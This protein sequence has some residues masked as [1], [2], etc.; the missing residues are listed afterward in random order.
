MIKSQDVVERHRVG[1]CFHKANCP[2]HKTHSASRCPLILPAPSETAFPHGLLDFAPSTVGSAPGTTVGGSC[3]KETLPAR[4]GKGAVGCGNQSFNDLRR[5]AEGAIAAPGCP[6]RH[7][8]QKRASATSN[9]GA[10]HL[11]TGKALPFGFD[12]CWSVREPICRCPSHS[13]APSWL[14]N[15]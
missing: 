2:A 4:S 5:R 9:R 13:K 8:D 10:A 14:R 15:R 1:Q 3:P 6:R 12:P 11:G 7:E